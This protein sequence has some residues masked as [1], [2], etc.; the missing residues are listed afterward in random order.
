MFTVGIT[1]LHG[2]SNAAGTPRIPCWVLLQG[3]WM[4]GSLDDQRVIWF[5]CH[6]KTQKRKVQSQKGQKHHQVREVVKQ[7]SAFF[8]LFSSNLL[9]DVQET[10]VQDIA[11]SFFKTVIGVALQNSKPESKENKLP[12]AKPKSVSGSMS[13][14][15][16]LSSCWTWSDWDCESQGF[17]LLSWACTWGF[18]MQPSLNRKSIF[19]RGLPWDLILCETMTMSHSVIVANLGQKLLLILKRMSVLNE[20]TRPHRNS[21]TLSRTV[22]WGLGQCSWNAMPRQCQGNAKGLRG[23]VDDW[24]TFLLAEQWT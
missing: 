8:A 9:Q 2:P 22:P 17:A 23:S 4:S 13:N 5:I 21:V 11:L 15:V 6:K 14:Y 1:G 19:R 20:T 10:Y 3:L 7:G 24:M 16:K 18:R 12:R